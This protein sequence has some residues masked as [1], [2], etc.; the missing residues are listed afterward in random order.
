MQNEISKT[1]INSICF[2][3]FNVQSSRMFYS[4][5]L[6]KNAANNRNI[7]PAAMNMITYR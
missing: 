2:L 1:V 6:R 5:N 3:T 4:D 7:A